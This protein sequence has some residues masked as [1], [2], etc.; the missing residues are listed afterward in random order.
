MFE[1]D[2]EYFEARGFSAYQIYLA[3]K[4]HFSKSSYDYFKYDGKISAK[5]ETFDKRN[6]KYYFCKIAKNKTDAEIV[7]FFVPQFLVHG[8]AMWI[9][10]IAGDKGNKT[11][12]EWNRKME[13][14]T[15]TFRKELEEVF[16]KLNDKGHNPERMLLPFN[17]EPEK[18]PMIIR[19]YLWNEVSI[20][21]IIILDMLTGFISETERN[22][23]KGGMRIWQ[24]E[25]LRI[26]SYKPFLSIDTDQFK[27]VLKKLLKDHT[28]YE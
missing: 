2:Q 1:Y 14:L 25:K 26:E 20:E 23:D 4:L 16:D 18:F 3:L 15:E 6:D 7:L 12:I 9:G 13:S 19:L 10:E 21:T 11:F 24:E 27:K 5:K 28:I 17:G 8:S 22:L